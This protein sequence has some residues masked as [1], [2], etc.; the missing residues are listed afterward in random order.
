MDDRLATVTVPVHV[1][2][3]L[4]M[5]RPAS[6]AVMRTRCPAPFLSKLLLHD[7]KQNLSVVPAYAHSSVQNPADVKSRFQTDLLPHQC[8]PYAKL[9]NGT[10]V[11]PS[12]A[13]LRLRV[14][15]HVLPAT[16]RKPH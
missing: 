9:H 12:Q 15:L 13:D 16:Q 3:F 4:Q 11:L 5:L 6:P 10:P 7:V 2:S 1:Q 8:E 14:Q